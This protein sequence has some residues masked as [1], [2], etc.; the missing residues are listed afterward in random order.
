MA[1]RHGNARFKVRRFDIF[2]F[3]LSHEKLKELL[4]LCYLP[5]EWDPER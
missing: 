5:A 1:W 3:N 4:M 2:E